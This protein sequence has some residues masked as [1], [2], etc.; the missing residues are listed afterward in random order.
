[1]CYKN[2]VANENVMAPFSI[3]VFKHHKKK[4]GTYNVKISITQQRKRAYIDTTHYVTERKLS[5]DY[6]VKDT[7][8]L[9]DLYNTLTAEQLRAFI[10]FEVPESGRIHVAYGLFLLS[11]YLCGVNAVDLYNCASNISNGRLEYERSKTKEKRKDRAF[12][13]LIVPEP[14]IPFN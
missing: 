1:M 14:A 3:K 11:F 13:S 10:K 5:K 12:I 4:D 2:S 8:I 7:I 6:E 9:K